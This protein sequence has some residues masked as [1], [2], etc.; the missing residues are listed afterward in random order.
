MI[1]SI[2]ETSIKKE[3]VVYDTGAVCYGRKDIGFA[4]GIMVVRALSSENLGYHNTYC[5]PVPDQSTESILQC[6][7]C[8]SKAYHI[9]DIIDRLS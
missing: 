1:K 4:G 8:G 2:K 6:L 9:T 3:D 7:E 5:H